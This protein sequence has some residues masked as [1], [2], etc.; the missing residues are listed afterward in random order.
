MAISRKK[1]EAITK[2]YNAE[3]TLCDHRGIPYD[4][5]KYTFK[6]TISPHIHNM[7]H[8]FISKSRIPCISEIAQTFIIIFTS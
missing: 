1:Q 2:L 3:K 6:G 7:S 4:E 5:Y 8:G